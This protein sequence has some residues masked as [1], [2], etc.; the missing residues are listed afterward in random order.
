MA[1]GAGSL[2]ANGNSNGNGGGGKGKPASPKGREAFKSQR[3]ESEVSSPE[4]FCWS[5]ETPGGGKLWLEA[6]CPGPL[7]PPRGPPAPARPEPPRTAGSA[8]SAA[9]WTPDSAAPDPSPPV[10]CC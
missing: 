3:R 6:I 10:S 7:P 1:P 5:W 8:G 9:V 2:P 4:S